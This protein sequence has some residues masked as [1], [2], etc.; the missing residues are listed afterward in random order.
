MGYSTS[1]T[2]Q[3]QYKLE[4]F[5][6]EWY[7]TDSNNPVATYTN[8]KPGSYTFSV[9]SSNYQGEWNGETKSIRVQIHPPFWKSTWAYILYIIVTS[10][11]IIYS[12]YR[13]RKRMIDKQK[14]QFERLESEKEKELY[15]AKIDFFT[16][17]AH[18]I[19]TPLTLIKGPLENIL[20]KTI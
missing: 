13:F 16:N 8:L 20:K 7:T 3:L 4:G 6:K 12:I 14:L 19:R 5:D 2:N 1:G 18:E 11:L 15:H 17:I 10:G 9:K